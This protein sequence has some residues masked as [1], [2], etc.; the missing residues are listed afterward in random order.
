V[1]P[2]GLARAVRAPATIPPA[3]GAGTFKTGCPKVL[4]TASPT[5]FS[6]M[7][8]A[9]PGPN[10]ANHSILLVGNSAAKTEAPQSKTNANAT[11]LQH[12][13]L[14]MRLTSLFFPGRSVNSTRLIRRIFEKF[15]KM[16]EQRGYKEDQ[17]DQEGNEGHGAR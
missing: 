12:L 3:P 9:A 4:A 10:G 15:Q 8:E 5:I 6:D 13:F 2:S 1:Y 17:R 16:T 14:F 7:A 11:P